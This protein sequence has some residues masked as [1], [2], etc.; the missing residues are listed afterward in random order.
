MGDFI[1]RGFGYTYSMP[2]FVYILRCRDGTLYTGYTNNLE[3]RVRTHNTGKWA[4]YTRGRIP[5]ELVYS[6]SYETESEARKREI[7]VK[8]L[9]K[10]EKE[11]IIKKVATEVTT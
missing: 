8:K 4:K 2:H 7:E 11:E 5:V 6:E 1:L 10:K 3:K 9:S